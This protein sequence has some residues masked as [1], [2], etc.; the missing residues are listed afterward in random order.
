M[1]HY[2]IWSLL[3]IVVFTASCSKEQETQRSTKDAKKSEIVLLLPK[4]ADFLVKVKSLDT[5]LTSIPVSG[6][7]TSARFNQ[8][9]QEI[10]QTLQF[11][12][13]SLEDWREQGVDTT[14]EIG[15][16]GADTLWST[17]QEEPDMNL[18]VFIPVSDG[19]KVLD[20][21]KTSIQKES[22][23]V[24]I[25]QEGDLTMIEDPRDGH[26]AYLALKES[27][28]FLATNLQAQQD[29]K[30]FLQ[31]VLD[32][33]TSL[34]SLKAY[35]T[36]TSHLSPHEE[37]FVYVNA[38]QGVERN[39]ATFK[40]MAEMAG[41]PNSSKSFDYAADYEN[42]GVTLDF[43]SGDFIMKSFAG[44]VPGSPSA[45]LFEDVE[46]DKQVVLGVQESPVMLLSLAVNFAEYYRMFIKP[47]A[48]DMQS[49]LGVEPDTFKEEFGVEL[50]QDILNNLAGNLNLGVYDGASISMFNYNTLLTLNV[51]DAKAMSATLDN[52]VEA[53]H[54][55]YKANVRKETVSG[56]EAYM[57]NTGFLP[58]YLA[59]HE[60]NL[61]A[62]PGRAMF[63]K[64]LNSDVSSGFVQNIDENPLSE[65]LQGDTSVFYLNVAELLN[66][67]HNFASLVEGASGG[68]GLKK[69]HLQSIRQLQYILASGRFEDN[70][71]FG[72]FIIKTDFNESFFIGAGKLVE[73]FQ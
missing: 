60:K 28:L 42:M 29:A 35:N 64:A 50:E 38:K 7:N 24:S 16:M 34:S 1:K 21:L 67:Y 54:P 3:L 41:S 55:Q 31:A 51:R 23:D 20:K 61:I 69:Q 2:S 8:Q 62:S 12:P 19:Q 68:Q 18:L 53:L 65:T 10:Q 56:V 5:I 39:L 17:D 37:V 45:T 22:P 36:V 27:Y 26:R 72:E 32:G 52:I 70:A 25:V 30:T 6:T 58:V 63:E 11:D 4:S 48:R 40:S 13:F 44:L 59:L 46:F 47:F 14:R 33:N 43:D 57:I 49:E 9:Q 73:R 15:V 71:L 66:I